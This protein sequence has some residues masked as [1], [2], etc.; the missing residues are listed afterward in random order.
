MFPVLLR[1]LK[2]ACVAS[3]MTASFGEISCKSMMFECEKS[4]GF[5]E[6]HVECFGK[7]LLRGITKKICCQI[8]YETII[9][10]F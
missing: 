4:H 10:Y 3:C 2:L 1:P 9:K 6:N 5:F 7:T 8:R